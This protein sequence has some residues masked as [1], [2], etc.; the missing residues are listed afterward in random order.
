MI[1][2]TDLRNGMTI[3]V[4]G[5]IYLLTECQQVKPGKGSAFVRARMKN[6]RT[7]S[8][9]DR[10]FKAA[11]RVDDV[12]VER[13]QVQYQYTDGDLYYMMDLASY[14][15]IPVSASLLG[16]AVLF[17]KDNLTLNLLMTEHE[18]IGMEM[19]FF[20]ELRVAETEPGIRGD[21]ATGGTKPARLESGA[22]VQ[23]PLFINVGDMLK[24]DTR[25]KTY[26]ERV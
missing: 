10:T 12:R 14:E 3:L 19:P 4:D 6:V 8:V 13:R 11:D 21:T 2:A 22:V 5:D 20:V 15:Q 18:V 16:D 1:A 23:V 7:G 26:V 25:T 24:L 9:I 17:L